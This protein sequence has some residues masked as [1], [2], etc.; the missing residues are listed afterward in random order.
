MQTNEAIKYLPII[1]DEKKI[2]LSLK[3]DQAVIKLSTWT[4]ELGWCA[5]KTLRVDEDMLDD[6]HRLIA[7]ARSKLKSRNALEP[8]ETGSAGKVLDFPKFS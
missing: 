8:R 7:S 6:L 1:S 4:E 3:E 2:E 5:Q